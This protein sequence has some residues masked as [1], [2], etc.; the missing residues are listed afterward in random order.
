MNP[1]TKCPIDELQPFIDDQLSQQ[2]NVQI[3]SHLDQCAECRNRIDR[4]AGSAED[5]AVAGEAFT[6]AA[7]GLPSCDSSGLVPTQTEIGPDGRFDPSLIL[8]L[9]A[10]SDDPR[11]AGRIGP[12]EVTGIVGAGGMGVVLKAREPSL[13]RFVAIKM[14]SPHL[15]SSDSARKRFAREARAAAAVIHDN[16]IAIYQVA[17]WNDIPYL[18]MPY[19]PDPT[20]QQRID[21]QGPMDIESVL[22][23]GMQIARGLSAAHSQGL[24]HRDVK[25][26]NVLLSKGT[27]R[28]VITDFGLARAA[29]DASLTRAGTLAGTPHYM[30]PEQARGEPLDSR[31]DLFSLGSVIFTMLAGRPPVQQELG[32]ETINQIAAHQLPSL[33]D[34]GVSVP[35]WLLRLVD[36]LHD[37]DPRRRPESADEVAGL[38]E[39]CLSH[40]RQPTRHPLP[41]QLTATKRIGKR[42][43]VALGVAMLGVALAIGTVIVGRKEPRLPTQSI[44]RPVPE[45]PVGQVTEGEAIAIDPIRFDD[46]LRWDYVDNQMETIDQEIMRWEREFKADLEQP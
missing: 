31:S 28:A 26:A 35:D 33:G 18:V 37:R 1:T 16:V 4:L 7:D 45:T 38:L 9:M 34:L 23:I 25:P 5:W 41:A 22:S 21:E 44:D 13:D 6:G 20:L 10:P 15:A 8:Q 32:S 42:S 11:A 30:S 2:Q 39:Q 46:D 17:H 12:F 19:L 36:R 40:H 29:D 43:R 14:L 24:V 3:V 27:E